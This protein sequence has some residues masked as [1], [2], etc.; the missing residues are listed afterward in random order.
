MKRAAIIAA[1][2]AFGT[3]VLHSEVLQMSNSCLNVMLDD[4]TGR[5]MLETTGG[6]PAVP[7][8]SNQPLLYKK[9]P[10]TTMTTLNIDG[11]Y[12][13]FGSDQ[14][15]FVRRGVIDNN[16]IVTEWSVRGIDAVQE[17]SFT[18]GPS[19]GREDTL[20]VV[21]RLRNDSGST[22][23]VGLRILLDT[24]LGTRE[25]S[26]FGVPGMQNIDHEAQLYHDQ[27]PGSWYAFDSTD[28]PVVR[29]Q[30][31]LSGAGTVKP[32]RVV[33]ASWDRLFDNQWDFPVDASKDFRR[34]G[35][36]VVD[37]AVALLYDAL[38]MN[39]QENMYYCTYY[40]LYGANTFSSKDLSL[41]LGAPASLRSGPVPV[42]ADMKNSGSVMMDRVRMEI[43]LPAGVTVSA[44]ESNV[45]EFVKVNAGEVKNALW[46]L[47]TPAGKATNQIKVILTGWVNQNAQ[48]VTA[49]KT[50]EITGTGPTVVAATNQEVLTLAN[51][52]GIT[53]APVSN[54]TVTITNTN[55]VVISAPVVT[56]T[57]ITT[58][59]KVITAS[60][61][62]LGLQQEVANIDS[63]IGQIDQ[64]YQVLFGI[65]KNAAVTNAQFLHD[66]DYEIQLFETRLAEQ[67]SIL[68]NQLAGEK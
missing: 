65:Y 27:I 22:H 18:K 58:A 14:G 44:G 48:S 55:V 8:S 54:V 24:I 5:F 17:L 56:N 64:R 6:D 52:A 50:F 10:P 34:V 51:T 11:E 32:D 25:A 42:S 67:E 45:V 4:N 31:T 59:T 66:L 40:G 53:N 19:T 47:V 38:D 61:K 15:S 43:Q 20:S 35:T 30:G 26:W 49:E 21:Y 63:L 13:I 60:E 36:G 68:S 29:V 3:G 7:G 46:N 16:K 1:L 62:E 39:N 41:T 9:V 57:R 2:F 12:F 37:S 23:K 33:F 28:T